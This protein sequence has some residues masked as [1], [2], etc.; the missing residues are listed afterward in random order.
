MEKIDLKKLSKDQLIELLMQAQKPATA[1]PTLKPKPPI[2][3]PK[4]WVA[5]QRGPVPTPRKK[6]WVAAQRGPV[7][8]PRKSVKQ[9]AQVYEDKKPI[10]APRTQIQQTVTALK[11]HTVSYQIE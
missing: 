2:H 8:T 1:A 4:G 9:I 6:G 7:P 3:Q 11:G 10:P 5:A